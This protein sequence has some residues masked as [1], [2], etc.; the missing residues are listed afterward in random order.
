MTVTALKTN[1]MKKV[2]FKMKMKKYGEGK[3]PI[4]KDSKKTTTVEKI[5][6]IGGTIADTFVSREPFTAI[7]N[8]PKRYKLNKAYQRAL[9]TKK[10]K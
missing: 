3:N 7:G 9:S 5:K 10:Q 6:A 4:R 8:I 2:P 1:N